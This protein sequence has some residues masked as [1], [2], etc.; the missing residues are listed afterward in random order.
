MAFRDEEEALRHQIAL[1]GREIDALAKER[2][3]LE[4]ERRALASTIEEQASALVSQPRLVWG[5]GALAIAAL[6]AIL[7]FGLSAGAGGS[8]SDVLYGRVAAIEGAAPVEAGARCTTFLEP[9][10]GK[11]QDRE[12]RLAVLCGGRAIYGGP[13]S[14][15][16]DCDESSGLRSRCYDVSFSDDDGDPKMLFDRHARHIVV[17][18]PGWS[19]RIELTTPPRGA[20]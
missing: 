17:A 4:D 3:G 15:S 13:T 6:S 2:A 10:S 12:A 14:G 11:N 18:E 1:L 5:V 19:V 7:L 9:L 16:A 8:N 20:R